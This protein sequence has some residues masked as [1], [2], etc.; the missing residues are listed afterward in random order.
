MI[1]EYMLYDCKSIFSLELPENTIEIE[2]GAFAS[3]LSLRNVALPPNIMFFGSDIFLEDG[4]QAISDLQQLFGSGA[5]IIRDLQHRFDRL[6][7]HKL[8]YYQSYYQGVLQ[9]LIAAI[10]TRSGQRRTLRNKLDPTGNHQDCLGMTPLHIL[11]CSSVH[12]LEVYRLIVE[13]YPAN[14]ITED[15]WGALPLLYAIWGAAPVDI[16]QFLLARYQ[17]LYPN[18]ALNWTMMVETMGRC[19][20]PKESIENMLHVRQMH[21]P[22]QPIDWEYL[23]DEF[24]NLADPS[25]LCFEST[26]T[27]RMQFLFMCCMLSRVEGLAFK[28]WRDHIRHLIQTANFKSDENNSAILRSIREKLVHF[29]D[30]LPKL[31]EATSI[32]ELALWKKRI[33]ENNSQQNTFRQQKKIK[34]EGESNREQCRVTCGADVIIGHVLPYLISTGD[35]DSLSYESATDDWGSDGE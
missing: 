13:K 17:S 5:A 21:F 30:E 3:C 18:H 15:R 20:T 7:I 31:K 10:N 27:E 28:V 25:D 26:F 2:S 6:P 19:D 24:V 4:M 1:P 22:E 16:I 11:T 33:N 8:V 34:A 32:L 12:N 14:L 9:N 29:E 35:D 23:L